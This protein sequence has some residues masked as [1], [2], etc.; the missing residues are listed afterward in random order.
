MT[1]AI[2]S[3]SSRAAGSEA[4]NAFDQ[5]ILEEWA[6]WLRG[7]IDEEWRPGEWNGD[8]LLFVGDLD[9]PSISAGRCHH[10]L[11]DVPTD[12]SR[13]CTNCHKALRGL[14]MK[15]DEFEVSYVPQPNRTMNAVPPK[16]GVP[17]CQRDCISRS[18]CRSHYQGWISR[19]RTLLRHAAQPAQLDEAVAIWAATQ[20]PL[21]TM[22]ACDVRGC[23][24]EKSGP[25]GLCSAHRKAW[26][27]HLRSA[28]GPTHGQPV[29][30]AWVENATPYL[31]AH[32]FSL[33]PL[34]L[35]PRLELL[36]AIQKYDTRDTPLRLKS[37][38]GAV[39]A[40]SHLPNLALAGSIVPDLA[41][42]G[43]SGTNSFLK[44]V[45]EEVRHSFGRFRGIEEAESLTWELTRLST[46][47]PSQFSKTGVRRNAGSVDFS[48]IQQDWLRS[49]AMHW[50]LTV[51][52]DSRTLRDRIRSC[53]V[54]SR[55]LSSRPGGGNAPSDLGYADMTAVFNAFNTLMQPDGKPYG[56][57]Q[58]SS[59][60]RGFE[61]LLDFG[62]RDGRL[63]CLSSRFARHP[64]EHR[65]KIDVIEED[66]VGKAIPESVIRQL[67]QY[68]H[69]IGDGVVYGEL[70]PEQINEMLRTA[71]V[72]LR[73]TGRRPREV[74]GL[75]LNCLHYD[76]GEYE[77]IWDNTK[78]RRLRRRLPLA[79]METI[80]AI[81][82]WK[83]I[84]SGLEIP[85]QSAEFL[86]PA[87][88]E[89]SGTPRMMTGVLSSMIRSWVDSIPEIDSEEPG[90]DGRPLPLDRMLIFPY[91]FRH[92]FCQRYAD[93][94]VEPHVLQALM[95]HK[96]ADTT[97]TYYKV[98]AK[99]KREAIETIRPLTTDRNGAPAPMTSSTS[100]ELRSVAVAFGNCI[101]PSNVKA[102]G[103]A[104]PIR[105]QCAGCGSYRPDPSYLPAIDEHIRALK[106]DRELATAT[107]AADFVLR[108]FDD[109]IAAFQ[110]VRKKQKE[111][112][113][114]MPD[115]MRHEVEE[116]SKVLRRL[117]A[118][119]SHTAVSLGMPQF[120]PPEEEV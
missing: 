68:V 111:K 42:T 89:K 52:P 35:I 120:G 44:F 46:P 90:P 4:A 33:A 56:G 82:K 115:E 40:I 27:K 28:G 26:V 86:F 63:D 112:L 51:A 1:T 57:K 87:I 21:G 37:I 31:S 96:S 18:L 73:D 65:I 98:P 61:D 45:H 70:T 34:Q 12:S 110:E 39:R 22:P 53:T 66:E 97:A 104:C 6:C 47:L 72:I 36:Y 88:S 58:R 117:R 93:A 74:A 41:R 77:L 50:V 3:L 60:F 113:A 10:P 14:G 91:A 116:A 29:L 95:D 102:G 62:R 84:R 109:Q 119:D 101:E 38:K 107:D 105:F 94:G 16:C 54:A 79:D 85:M 100:Y 92:S 71:Y 17:G 118:R 108:N 59:L 24:S 76:S 114:L 75:E 99:M 64:K 11:C 81:K 20:N 23:R 103:K 9:S 2:A 19:G 30:S 5:N 7:E 78:S 49:L 69:L 55:A 67:D 80:A 13:Y 106:A 48:T 32:M 8:L 43:D 83:K 25:A 15:A